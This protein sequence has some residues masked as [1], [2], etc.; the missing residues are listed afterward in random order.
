MHLLLLFVKFYK[1]AALA[2]HAHKS[3]RQEHFYR[4][5]GGAVKKA[6]KFQ[7]SAV[8]LGV[9]KSNIPHTWVFPAARR[10]I[11]AS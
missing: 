4:Q 2:P 10:Y 9:V 3:G 8:G 7:G 11:A 1:A 6:G 5:L